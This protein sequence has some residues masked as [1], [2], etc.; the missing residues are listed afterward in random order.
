M[1]SMKTL[2]RL[3]PLLLLSSILFATPRPDVPIPEDAHRES[4]ERRAIQKRKAA[5]EA[6]RKA[7]KKPNAKL[8][9]LG[10][11]VLGIGV[12]LFVYGLFI[13]SASIQV[14]WMLVALAV[15]L[16]GF[17]IWNGGRRK[18]TPP[19]AP[20]P[21]KPRPQSQPETN[22]TRPPTDTPN[23]RIPT[24]EIPPFITRRNRRWAKQR[25]RVLRTSPQARERLERR[26][27]R[28]RQ[29]NATPREAWWS[30]QAL[31]PL[32]LVLAGAAGILFIVALV[33]FY[34][35]EPIAWALIGGGLVTLLQLVMEGLHRTAVAELVILWEDGFWESTPEATD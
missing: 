2:I 15:G 12:A 6:V 4:V 27:E 21:R 28:L 19:P 24:A 30:L 7:R 31:L 20:R 22:P 35:E 1:Y 13:S 29:R 11:A 23:R 34:S 10:L 32:K 18:P 26:A 16:L 9:N 17:L 14:T 3:L 25:R 5:K 8:R 33:R